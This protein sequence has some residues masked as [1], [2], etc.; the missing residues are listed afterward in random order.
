MF[1]KT[2][3]AVLASIPGAAKPSAFFLGL[4]TLALV[5]VLAGCVPS[6]PA[7]SPSTP[8]ST[9]TTLPGLLTVRGTVTDVML[10]AR[11]LTVETDQ[12]PMD[13]A[14][15]EK[16]RILGPDGTPIPL[17]DIRPGDVIEA[18]GRLATGGG[19]IPEEVRVLK[20]ASKPTPPPGVPQGGM[21][22]T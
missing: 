13:V 15:T 16:T 22:P 4:L 9:P 11:V 21:P 2:L 14:L 1:R 20:A 18:T 17:R 8:P 19:V 5:L 7:S 10:S 6:T 3:T 12:G